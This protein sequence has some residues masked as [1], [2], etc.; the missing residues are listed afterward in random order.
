MVKPLMFLILLSLVFLSGCS[1]DTGKVVETTKLT[2]PET[3]S[4]QSQVQAPENIEELHKEFE[5]FEKSQDE[6]LSAEQNETQEVSTE[7]MEEV[8]ASAA[9]DETVPEEE[10]STQNESVQCPHAR[11]TIPVQRIPA[12]KRQIMNASMMP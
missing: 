9:G 3:P 1:T 10:A 6:N 2:I 11:I 7:N 4:G 12:P 8:P 5:E